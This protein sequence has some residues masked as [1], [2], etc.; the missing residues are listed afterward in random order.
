MLREKERYSLAHQRR[1]IELAS[2]L[3]PPLYPSF[4]AVARIALRKELA[5]LVDFEPDPELKQGLSALETQLESE[6][7]K[8]Y[9]GAGAAGAQK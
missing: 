5:R 9:A 8:Q 4:S 3:T 2:Q 1:A 7:E 6:S